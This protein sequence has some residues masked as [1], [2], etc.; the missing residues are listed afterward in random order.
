M[1]MVHAF[2]MVKTGPGKSEAMVEAAREVEAVAEAHIV[3]GDY[4]LVVEVET[5]EVYEV[6]HAAS[7]ELQ[8]LDG[9]ENTKTYISL[10]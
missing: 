5:E 9:I 8:G 4:D 1:V 2:V 10:D 7:T 6:L 3:A